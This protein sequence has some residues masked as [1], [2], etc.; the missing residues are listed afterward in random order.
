MKLRKM[1]LEGCRT[2]KMIPDRSVNIKTGYRLDGRGKSFSP[3]QSFQ[4]SSGAHPASYPMGTRAL[5]LGDKTAGVSSLL[6]VP[7]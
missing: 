1:N 5:S 6:L 2:I 7:R 3:L 4:T